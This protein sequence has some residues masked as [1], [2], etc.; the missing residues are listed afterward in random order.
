MAGY[1]FCDIVMW[2]YMLMVC[3]R[4]WCR[5]YFLLSRDYCQFTASTA[6]ER[7]CRVFVRV[8][9]CARTVGCVGVVAQC[10]RHGKARSV[11]CVNVVVCF[12][13]T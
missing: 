8:A 12:R 7:F 3:R 6:D 11:V 2:I 4:D 13:S 5:V 9:F 1:V 10:V